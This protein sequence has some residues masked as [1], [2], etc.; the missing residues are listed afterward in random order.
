M[1]KQMPLLAELSNCLSAYTETSY[2]IFM[3]IKN[4]CDSTHKKH[5]SPTIIQVQDLLSIDAELRRHLRRMEDWSERQQT[6]ERLEEELTDLSTRVNKFAQ[7]LSSTQ[8]ALQGCLVTASKLQ[9]GVMQGDQMATIEDFI[10]TSQ[11]IS[12]T[13]SGAPRN[14][15]IFPW[16]PDMAKMQSGSL[17]VD[18]LHI[19]LPAVTSQSVS[20][21]PVNM[22][23]NAVLPSSSSG[24]SSGSDDE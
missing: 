20:R 23:R 17:A 7:V 18:G 1:A 6:I 2:R 13:V 21:E 8:T 24:S 14:D 10:N 19:E 5:D 15:I 3:C 9:K 4:T 11:N 12:R 16:M 22:T